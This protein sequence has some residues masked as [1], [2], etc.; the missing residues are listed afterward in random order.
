MSDSGRDDRITRY[1][2]YKT[3][4]H[5]G[6]PEFCRSRTH[7][8]GV[9]LIDVV[10]ECLDVICRQSTKDATLLYAC[11][12]EA[13]TSGNKRHAIA[14]LEKVLVKYDYSAPADVHLPALLRQVLRPTL[15]HFPD[16]AIG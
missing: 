16:I 3:G 5:L 13:Q 12:L 1:L 7:V 15:C 8:V 6:D 9:T 10:A 2:M 4:L 14:A 11:I